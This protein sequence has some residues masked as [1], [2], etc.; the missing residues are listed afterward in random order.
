MIILE[1]LYFLFW[2]LCCVLS[3]YLPWIGRKLLKFRKIPI[4]EQKDTSI[5]LGVVASVS[6][7]AVLF[8]SL[9]FWEILIA[10][11][12][13]LLLLLIGWIDWHTGYILDQLT[14]GG[15]LVIVGFELIFYPSILPV[16][17]INS[18]LIFL[19]LYLLAK[20]TKRLGEGDAKLMA[21]CALLMDWQSVLLALWIASISGLVFMTI[22]SLHKKIEIRQY[23]LPFGPHLALGAFSSYLYGEQALNLFFG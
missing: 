4:Q 7:V 23:A 22:L 16:Q 15:S 1:I 13:L 6:G 21:M 18:I 12:F 8:R 20:G 14:I 10:F 2:V 11:I 5:I 3:F 19:C 17:L 9:N